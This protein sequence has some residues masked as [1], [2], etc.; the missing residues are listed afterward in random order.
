MTGMLHTIPRWARREAHQVYR[1]V[2]R[3]LGRRLAYRTVTGLQRVVLNQG[4]TLQTGNLVV[5][6]RDVHRAVLVLVIY[7][8]MDRDRLM[9]G[10][11]RATSAILGILTACL[12]A[13]L[14]RV[15][16]RT[17]MCRLY[18]RTPQFWFAGADGHRS[19]LQRL[20]TL[21][22]KR[23]LANF[24]AVRRRREWR[25]Q[26]QQHDLLVALDSGGYQAWLQG[27]ELDFGAWA[28]FVSSHQDLLVWY[29]QPD[30]PGAG[31]EANRGYLLRSEQLGLTPTPTFHIDMPLDY[32][33][34]LL[35]RGY[36]YIA[37]GGHTRIK[38][39]KARR[40]RIREIQVRIRKQAADHVLGSMNLEESSSCDAGTWTRARAGRSV[41][42]P[43]GRVKVAHGEI[44]WDELTSLAILQIVGWQEQVASGT[45]QLSFPVDVVARCGSEVVQAAWCR[46]VP[47]QQQLRIVG[48]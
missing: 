19:D 33:T 40:A 7:G 9:K 10:P 6:W 4:R 38:D 1:R 44:P 17:G 48:L 21:G 45:A 2:Q 16:L 43:L 25:E 11:V 18:R 30:K 36:P 13:E 26:V 34:W 20:S 8:Y 24:F 31:V 32:L 27:S 3:R 15:R 5:P 46:P 29:V 22:G 47:T 23:M 39:E 37:I 14:R 12:G 41:W 35:D 42:T 28:V